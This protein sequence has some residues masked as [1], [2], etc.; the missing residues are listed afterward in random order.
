MF[1]RCLESYGRFGC[2]KGSIS[3]M[4][5]ILHDSAIAAASAA[6]A[7]TRSRAVLLAMVTMEELIQGFVF[8]SY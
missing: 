2:F 6:V 8:L 3:C 5:A 7:R 4:A 1:R